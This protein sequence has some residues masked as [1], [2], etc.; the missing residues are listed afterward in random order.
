MAAFVVA[1]LALTGAGWHLLRTLRPKLD[2]RLLRIATYR[3]AARGGSVF[4]AVMSAIP[5]LLPVLPAGLRLDG[6]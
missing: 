1:V 2:L 6:R 5:F 4:R 3:A